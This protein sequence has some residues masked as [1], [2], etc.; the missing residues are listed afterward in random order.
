MS[1]LLHNKV[2]FA[3]DNSEDLHTQAKFLRFIDTLRA[4]SE[5]TSEPVLGIGCW[6]GGLE[7]IV[8]MDYNDYME[9]VESIGFVEAQECVLVL[10]PVNP[11]QIHRK[12]GT[13]VFSDGKKVSIGEWTKISEKDAKA[14]KNYSY[15]PHDD[16]YWAC[17]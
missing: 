14:S 10:N 16:S 15:F 17:L 9:Y 7:T 12:Q 5:L 1:K 6:D 3:I 11:R 2:V 4:K 13:L 8:S